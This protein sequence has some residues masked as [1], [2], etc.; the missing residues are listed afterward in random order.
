MGPPAPPELLRA[1]ALVEW[2]SDRHLR[3]APAR[4]PRDLPA[5]LADYRSAFPELPFQPE[6]PEGWPGSRREV[7]AAAFHGDRQA[8]QLRFR[9]REGHGSLFLLAAGE[10]PP[11]R[12]VRGGLQVRVLPPGRLA[13]V[14]VEAADP[15]Q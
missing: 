1:H 12:F 8:L 15:P 6:W 2:A 9:D 14:V 10:A 5:E 3:P 4:L 13:A 11:A 7:L